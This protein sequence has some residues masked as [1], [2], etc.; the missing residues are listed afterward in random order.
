MDDSGVRDLGKA[1]GSVESLLRGKDPRSTLDLILD[2]AIEDAGA[3]CAFLL[4]VD[5]LGLFQVRVAR[6]LKAPMLVTAETSLTIVRRAIARMTPYLV[7]DARSAED[8]KKE[9]SVKRH[10]LRSVLVTPLI[11]RGEPIGAI[12]I[13]HRTQKDVFTERT[14]ALLD[15]LTQFA[16]QAIARLQDAATE[17]MESDPSPR[18]EPE[19][20]FAE[21]IGKSAL[22]MNL[23]ARLKRACASEVP[24]LVTGEAG[25][26]KELVA[27]ALHKNGLRRNKAFLAL[28]ASTVA[29]ASSE[30]LFQA[31]HEGTIFLDEVGEASPELQ[32][33]LLRA[34]REKTDVRVIA[35]THRDLAKMV[36]EGT[37]REDL[38]HHLNGMALP[39]PPLAKR[40]GDVKLLTD[41]FLV[42]LGRQQRRQPRRLTE[43]A[44]VLLE[45]HAWPG[46]VPE[47]RSAIERAHANGGDLLEAE[48]FELEERL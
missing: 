28:D 1:L 17:P 34:L 23:K 35:A 21:L 32:E 4:T 40:K 16:V 41:H 47:L 44:R 45:N 8:F 13:E 42:E 33:K 22:M 27:R 6:K 48:D 19:P 15:H 11:S 14:V 25:T 38:Y 39:V 5:A 43:E 36:A 12:V 20:P 7:G 18:A 3:E 37:F 26:G 29:L 30:G 2:T 9:I 24:V 10:N 46:N 31:A